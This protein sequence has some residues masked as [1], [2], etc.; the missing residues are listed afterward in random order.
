MQS[1]WNQNYTH[2]PAWVTGSQTFF[3][4]YHSFYNLH[5]KVEPTFKLPFASFRFLRGQRLN[6]FSDVWTN[7]IRISVR[8]KGLPSPKLT[9]P[10]KL[11]RFRQRETLPPD[12]VKD[13][14]FSKLS[15]TGDRFAS[16]IH[17]KLTYPSYP[18]TNLLVLED[19]ICFWVLHIVPFRVGHPFIF[20]G[21]SGSQQT[22]ANHSLGPTL[23]TYQANEQKNTHRYKGDP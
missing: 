15:P 20:R 19:E 4:N 8:N 3:E 10:W 5:N 11:P 1:G 18:P 13:P 22:T 16:F 23:V 12:E 21:P 17:W 7:Q 2:L 9:Y 6:T 14:K